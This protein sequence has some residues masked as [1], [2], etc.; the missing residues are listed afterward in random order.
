MTCHP[1]VFSFLLEEDLAV[2]QRLA[3]I[4]FL[5]NIIEDV[6]YSGLKLRFSAEPRELNWSEAVRS[7]FTTFI[8]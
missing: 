6:I 2:W 3:D 7:Y 5:V 8:L 1:D 4:L